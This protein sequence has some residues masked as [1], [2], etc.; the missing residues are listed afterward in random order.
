[1][2]VWH[3]SVGSRRR[4]QIPWCRMYRELWIIQCGCHAGDWIWVLSMSSVMTYLGCQ[5]DYIWSRRNSK[6][7]GSLWAIVLTG[8]PEASLHF[9]VAA[10]IIGPKRE[11]YFLL[12][13]FPQSHWQSSLIPCG[14]IP[15]MHWSLYLQIP[16]NTESRDPLGHQHQ[17]RTIESPSV[18][19]WI[20]GS[21][22]LG[23]I[24]KQPL[25]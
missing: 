1:M 8:S 17:I 20:L 14:G 21:W 3:V 2:C 9:L 12:L 25:E 16:M 18:M 19:N 23:D 13:L 22:P 11:K 4:C 6:Q 10:H 5:L 7:L 24:G 15:S